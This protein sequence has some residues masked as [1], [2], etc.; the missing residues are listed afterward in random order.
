MKSK[1]SRVV[2]VIGDVVDSRAHPSRRQMQESLIEALNQVNQRLEAIQPLEPTIGDE[3]QAVY[4]TVG[5]ALRA[6]LLVRLALPEDIDTRFGLGWGSLVVVGESAYGLTQD[7]PAWWAARAAVDEV[8]ER[9]RRIPGLHT[10]L[11]VPNVQDPTPDTR[12][13]AD[14][15]SIMTAVNSYVLCRDQ[16]VS[17]FDGRER[18]IA[19]GVLDGRTLASIAD[20]EEVSASAISQRFRRGINAVVE[21]AQQVPV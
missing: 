18:R 11:H 9:Q 6:T 5:D 20:D 14:D 13:D 7:G 4:G 21:S 1:S 10:W 19:W 12:K 15:M 8:E 16:L 2:A 17:G 3:F